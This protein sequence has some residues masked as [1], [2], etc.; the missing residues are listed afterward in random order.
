M[1]FF[2]SVF[3]VPTKAVTEHAHHAKLVSYICIILYSSSLVLHKT[4]QVTSLSDLSQQCTRTNSESISNFT[5]EVFGFPAPSSNFRPWLYSASTW[6]SSRATRLQWSC[7]HGNLSAPVAGGQ[8]M[9]VA[10]WTETP[11]PS[12][13]GVSAAITV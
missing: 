1:I 7:N 9:R 11:S 13:G 2:A 5:P 12:A 3:R 4:H 10:V 6:H 8:L